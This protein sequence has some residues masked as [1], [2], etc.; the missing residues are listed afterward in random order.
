MISLKTK[1]R[2]ASIYGVRGLF[3]DPRSG[4]RY[5]IIEKLGR[6]WVEQR[7]IR[8]GRFRFWCHA[9][10]LSDA[11]EAIGITHNERQ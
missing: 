5:R 9:E 4:T 7:T 11:L 1:A 10:S 6:F 8:D 3:E 2:D